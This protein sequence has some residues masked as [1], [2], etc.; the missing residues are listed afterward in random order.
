MILTPREIAAELKTLLHLSLA[1]EANADEVVIRGAQAAIRQIVGDAEG[2]DWDEKTTP[3]K[4]GESLYDLL[5]EQDEG[6]MKV[7]EVIYCSY[8]GR[9]LDRID[10]RDLMS[11]SERMGTVTPTQAMF[12]ISGRNLCGPVM[13]TLRYKEDRTFLL[14]SPAPAADDRDITIYCRNYPKPPQNINDAIRIPS[15]YWN[16]M[17]HLSA[18]YYWDVM[19]ERTRANEERAEYRAAMVKANNAR[20]ERGPQPE[21]INETRYRY[22]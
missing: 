2:I 3:S 12:G 19:K 11:A 5:L 14:V 22:G 1:T 18:A 21:K 4:A 6:E 7:K 13:W 15:D 9:M 16:A 17:R 10:R 8:D 20:R